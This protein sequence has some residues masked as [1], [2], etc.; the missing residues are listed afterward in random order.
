MEFLQ[1]LFKTHARVFELFLQRIT[2]TK[3]HSDKKLINSIPH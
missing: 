2:I 3:K 1:L